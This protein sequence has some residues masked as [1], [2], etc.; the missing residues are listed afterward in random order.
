MPV[1]W[2]YR[3]FP[4][5]YKLNLSILK[6]PGKSFLVIAKLLILVNSPSHPKKFFTDYAKYS[7]MYATTHFCS[8]DIDTSKEH[9]DEIRKI[10]ET[11]FSQIPGYKERFDELEIKIK[12]HYKVDVLWDAFLAERSVGLSDLEIDLATKV[13]EKGTLAKHAHMTAYAYY[14]EQNFDKAKE[15]FENRVLKLVE[16][17]TLKASDVPGLEKEV[18]KNQT[19]ICHIKKT[20]CCMGCLYKIR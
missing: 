12:A 11:K 2:I 8:G 14:C 3:F 7:L 1:P 13:C 6:I 20:G 5:R 17:T 19:V 16:R 15:Y 18:E 9:M 4:F 10:G